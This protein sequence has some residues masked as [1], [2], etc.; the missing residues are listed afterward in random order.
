MKSKFL[1]F[2]VLIVGLILVVSL[3]RSLWKLY[4]AQE[5]LHSLEQAVEAEEEEKKRLEKVA[6]WRKS[7][8]YVEQEARNR[9]QMV[10][11]GEKMVVLPRKIADNNSTDNSGDVLSLNSTSEEVSAVWKQWVELLGF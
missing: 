8:E 10:K 3:A 1:S 4:S 11:E 7:L 5:R 6:S 9:L 2:F